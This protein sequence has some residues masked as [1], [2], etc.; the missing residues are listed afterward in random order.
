MKKIF[1][2]LFVLLFAGLHGN[3]Q[4][5]DGELDKPATLEDRYEFTVVTEVGVTPV[6]DQSRSGTC[7]SFSANAFLESELLRL[8]KGEYNL[9][10]MWVVRNTYIDKAEKYVRM[11]GHVNFSAGG[12]FHDVFNVYRKYGMMPEEAYAGLNYGAANHNHSELDAVLQGYLKAVISNRKL[13]TS[14][15]EGYIG[16]L[17]AYLG[18][19]PETFEYKGKQ[20]TPKSFAESLG[21]DMDDYV[22]LTSYTHHPFYSSFILEI[23]DNW[24][25]GSSYNIPLDEFMATMDNALNTGYSIAWGSDV[26]EKGFRYSNGFAIAPAEQEQ[27]LEGT[28]L[29]RW[30]KLS[31]DSKML[32]MLDKSGEIVVTQEIRQQAFDN[33]ETTDDHGMQITGIAK[34]QRGDKFYKVKNSWGTNQKYEGYFYASAPFVAYKTMN[35]IVHKDALTKDVRKKLQIK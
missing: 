33:Y 23:P 35:V 10:E 17:D 5:Q 27:T 32:E 16:I 24:A 26:S 12:A 13:T 14:W 8:G 34:D 1:S 7:W 19:V 30:V 20:Y 25:W 3:V 31:E 9:S 2:I 18:A 21:L 11:H 22:S 15:K 4:A 29:S 6:G 28:E